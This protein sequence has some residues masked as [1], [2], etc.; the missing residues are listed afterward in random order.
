MN[1]MIERFI[2]YV[3]VNTQSKEDSETFPST[4][5]QLELANIIKEDL[6]GMGFDASVSEHG[7]VYVFIPKN[8]DADSPKIGFLAHLD[9]SPE[10]T[11]QKVN[12][13]LVEKYDGNDVVLNP[14][15]NITLS[16]QKFPILKEFIGNDLIVT[17][18]TTLLGADDKAGVVEIIQA[19]KEIKIE[20]L[21][22]GDIYIAFTPDEEVGHG[23]DKIDL[24]IFKPDFAYT[25]DGE[26]YGI[27]EYENFNAALLKY[28]IHGINTHPGTAKGAMKN[29]IK[30]S[31]ELMFL[32]PPLETPEATQGYEGFYHFYEI[33]GGVEEVNLKAIIRD[34]DKTKFQLRKY[35]AENI[36]NFLNDKYGEG[37]VSIEIKD[38]YYNM[39][40]IIEKHQEVLDLAK[41]AFE[42][43]GLEFKSK[44]IRG[45]TDGA[46]LTYMG[47]PTPNI[48][49]GGYN[50]HSIYEFVSVQAM[51]KA[52]EVVKNIILLATQKG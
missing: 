28:K 21:P 6:I 51:E 26:G 35:F 5:G 49:S 22:H 48:F 44:P 11:A 32:F 31:Q 18:G 38:Q 7:Y 25:L 39:R 42:R 40:E 52:K 30:I 50:Y 15:K 1:E 36:A 43:T 3:K 33:N 24:S 41:R 46:R 20:N 13:K 19:I 47:I 14:E 37:T 27:F 16:P 34:H 10:V 45:G 17:D 9:T 23:V 2:K 12:P 8:I 29:A 4:P